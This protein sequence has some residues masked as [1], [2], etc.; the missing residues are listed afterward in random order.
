MHNLAYLP[1]KIDILFT[2]PF[3]YHFFTLEVQ[4]ANSLLQRVIPVTQLED[5]CLPEQPLPKFPL[6]Q[7]L[8]QC[9]ENLDQMAPPWEIHPIGN[10]KKY[11]KREINVT[12]PLVCA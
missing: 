7:E 5:P 8:M 9:Q 6:C 1:V 4:A 10:K 12:S 3:F 2:S 11:A